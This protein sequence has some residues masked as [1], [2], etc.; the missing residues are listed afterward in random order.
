M[1][2]QLILKNGSEGSILR[3]RTNGVIFCGFHWLTIVIPS[4]GSNWCWKRLIKKLNV[5][6]CIG[7]VM[8]NEDHMYVEL[9]QARACKFLKTSSSSLTSKACLTLRRPP[10]AAIS[11]S[12][13]SIGYQILAEYVSFHMRHYLLVWVFNWPNNPGAL[14][15]SKACLQDVIIEHELLGSLTINVNLSYS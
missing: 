7:L 2:V 10:E 8:T 11:T 13:T 4:W 1:Y 15:L 6:A 9:K 14:G 3:E 12:A 5:T